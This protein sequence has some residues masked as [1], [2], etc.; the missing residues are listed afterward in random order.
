MI[1]G[2]LLALPAGLIMALPGKSVRPE[3]LAIGMGIYFTCHYGGIG[4][5]SAMAGL[6]RDLTGSPAAPLWFAGAMLILATF[7]LLQYR[8]LYGRPPHT[9]NA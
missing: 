1:I 7:M 6:T 2:L 3:R 8:L 9:A 4:L 5:L